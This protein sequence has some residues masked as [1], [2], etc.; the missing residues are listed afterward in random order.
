M[1]SLIF[2]DIYGRLGRKAFLRELPKLREQYQSDIVIANIENITSWRG[3][4]TEHAQ[5]IHDAWVDVMTTWDH[6]FDNFDNISEYFQKT[7]SNLIRPAN[8]YESGDSSYPGA[9][10]K[11]CTIWN[12]QVAVLQLLWTVFMRHSVKNPFHCVDEILEIPE[13]AACPIKI[14]DF[15]RET[16]AELY[17][18]ANYLDGRVSCVYGTHTHIQTSDAHILPN[19]TWLIADIGMNG[20]KLWII[21]AD[22]GS[23]KKRFLTGMQRGKIEQQLSGEVQISWLCIDCDDESGICRS[24][25][26]IYYLATQ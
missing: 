15:H 16:T 12:T 17:G 3:P 21:G 9:G 5:L 6:A 26:A 1:K 8:F 2:W 14:L 4:I 24:I 13:V 11:I 19:G 20:P 10:Y 23:V 25:E 22:F 7:D 18:M